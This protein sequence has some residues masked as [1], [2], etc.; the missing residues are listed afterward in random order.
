MNGHA[1]APDAKFCV[2]C[3]LAVAA[4]AP[5]AAQESPGISRSVPEFGSGFSAPVPTVNITMT[6]YGTDGCSIGLG[7]L[8][9]PGS[10]V[11]LSADG[12]LVGTTM[13]SE[14]GTETYGGCE[15]DDAI[16]DVTTKASTYSLAIGSRG[17][18]SSS[19]SELK[20]N[21]WLFQATLGD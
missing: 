15:F 5:V 12:E 10:I 17:E 11:V 14:Y 3:G 2:V 9:V 1:N 8:D 16:P 19:N 6:I 21:S 20:G 4:T 13:L 7:Y 18:I